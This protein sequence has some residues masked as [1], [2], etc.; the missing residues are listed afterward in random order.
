[1]LYQNK[2]NHIKTYSDNYSQEKFFEY[3]G[4][5]I[6]ES[7]EWYDDHTTQRVTLYKT[8]EDAENYKNE[9]AHK[10]YCYDEK[11]VIKFI[12]SVI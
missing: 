9:I 12:N 1:M 6:L 3:N 4:L 5:I 2:L 10:C 8:L 7:H 11:E